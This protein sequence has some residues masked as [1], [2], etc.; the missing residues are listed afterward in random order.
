MSDSDIEDY[1]PSNKNII[2]DT[3]DYT[4]G[5]IIKTFIDPKNSQTFCDYKIIMKNNHNG[6]YR[7]DIYVKWLQYEDKQ[8]L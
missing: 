1:Y 7:H 6:Y 3:E 2:H 5:I 4:A 8:E